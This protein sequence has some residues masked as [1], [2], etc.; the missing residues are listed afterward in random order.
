[1]NPQSARGLT[2]C[3]SLAAL[4]PG[5]CSPWSSRLEP[6]AHDCYVQTPTELLDLHE[7]FGLAV[8][9]AVGGVLLVVGVRQ[10]VG[11]ED[12]VADTDLVGQF[13]ALIQFAGSQA[14]TGAG[15]GNRI[16]AQG[17]LGGLGQDRAIEPA[18]KRNRAAPVASQNVEQLVA[19]GGYVV[20]QFGHERIEYRQKWQA[21]QRA[22][23]R[24]K[25]VPH[26]NAVAMRC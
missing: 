8:V 9:A 11:L 18:G 23:S 19:F 17:Q 2:T 13:A 16:V 5:R 1:M 7:E 4:R 20:G 26:R 25:V 15:D 14:G 24:N 3:C 21:D 6:S 22:T 10:F 12:F